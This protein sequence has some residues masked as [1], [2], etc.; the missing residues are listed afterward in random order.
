M[1]VMI[2]VGVMRSGKQLSEK[3][4]LTSER[5]LISRRL[6]ANWQKSVINIDRFNAL[7]AANP[8]LEKQ[9]AS[10]EEGVT[11]LIL[12]MDG[13]LKLLSMKELETLDKEGI[14]EAAVVSQ[15]N[16]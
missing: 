8:A 14:D 7:K 1:T 3:P 9:M 5:E 2:N 16:P 15:L 4:L 12:E 6:P 11:H 13:A 10:V